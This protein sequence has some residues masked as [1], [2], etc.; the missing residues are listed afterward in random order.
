MENNP[1][2]PK[3]N[4]KETGL[5]E[6]V[7]PPEKTAQA[8]APEPDRMF[9]LPLVDEKIV[10]F[11]EF[12]K[13]GKPLEVHFDATGP[14][15]QPFL[16]YADEHN[17]TYF[18]VR[19]SGFDG[20]APSLL[21][22]A[23]RVCTVYRFSR[24]LDVAS[25]T[26]VFARPVRRGMIRD[27]MLKDYLP[28]ASVATYPEL[29]ESDLENMPA[30]QAGHIRLLI[31]GARKEIQRILSSEFI[32]QEFESVVSEAMYHK[33]ITNMIDFV[34]QHCLLSETNS[35]RL[36][37]EFDEEKRLSMLIGILAEESELRELLI[38][39][40]K[41]A[42]RR[43][44]ESQKEYYMRE[45]IRSLQEELG[46]R[47]DYTAKIEAAKLPP[48][49][50]EKLLKDVSRMQKL[51]SGS[52][53]YS[54]MSAYLDTVLELPWH[55]KTE[56]VLDLQRSSEILERDHYGLEPVKERI[57][58]FIAVRRRNPKLRNQILCLVGP[59]GT[60]KTSICAS[61]AE[62]MNRK[63]IRVSLGGVDDESIIR[64]HRKT[65]IGAMPGRI[66]DAV[67]RA[68]S[69]NPVLVLDEVDK[70]VDN[71]RGDPASALLEVLD[72]EQNKAF[73]D[74]YIEVP[75]DLSDVLFIA[76][77]NSISRIP[78]PLFDRMEVITLPPYT[79]T[80]KFQIARRHL[81]PKQFER[82]SVSETEVRLTDAALKCVIEEYTF[83][84]GVRNLERR[85][86]E[87]AR[88]AARHL[89]DGS[90]KAPISV[91]LKNLS[92]F[93]EKKESQKE[94]IGERDEIGIVNGLSVTSVGGSMMQ[95]EALS[96]DGSGK[97]ET[98]GSLGDVLKESIQL[99][100]S[101][102]RS[103]AG[104]YQIDPEFYKKHDIH[105][106]FP[107]GAVSKDG[108]SAGVSITTA[109][110]SALTNRPVRRDVAMTGEID[111]RGSV[112]AIGGLR[113]K[114]MAAYSAGAT[115]V[116]F[117]K[118]NLDDV[119]EIDK[120]VSEHV[121]LIPV[122]RVDEILKDVLL[123]PVLPDTGAKNAQAGR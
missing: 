10:P 101:Y 73:Q 54:L 66:M 40:E 79:P 114:T 7:R 117:P 5:E 20:I 89:E 100:V 35:L 104:R 80:E 41:E 21:K 67:T 111:L 94:K 75:F 6:E 118:G 43:M 22:K 11:P 112:L 47:D 44:A 105:L 120:E 1:N 64:G 109:L 62:A 123:P 39:A 3:R 8:P 87:I 34:A 58:D 102:I 50:S 97:M 48:K 68:Q 46:D 53:D 107:E 86:A 2:K 113:E 61:I 36:F 37:T 51:Q 26:Y 116:Y 106:H 28:L 42:S 65:Y 18:A 83:E 59:P 99:A 91:T 32:G 27:S 29:N 14:L 15:W 60:G 81:I 17:I 52:P 19:P 38:K 96:L 90:M 103:I 33:N 78:R 122:S 121:R 77:A 92:Q 23:R 74:H 85:M 119:K 115:T 56:D 45:R 108:P 71:G 30:E 13:D 49:V 82:N 69:S 95:V 63:Y 57:L 12:S 25:N 72:A 55:K 9:H 93:L 110:V 76:T 16:Q 98:T 88:K 70:L 24:I 84:A 31:E 4:H